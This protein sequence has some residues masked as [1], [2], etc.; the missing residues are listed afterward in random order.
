MTDVSVLAR[1]ARDTWGFL[2]V[3]VALVTVVFALVSSLL[4]IGAAKF[5]TIGSILDTALKLYVFVI[6]IIAVGHLV[7]LV[8]GVGAWFR[9]NDRRI[10]GTFGIFLNIGFVMGSIVAVIGTLRY[11]L[12]PYTGFSV[13]SFPWS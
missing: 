9:R 8:L 12:T 5:T 3:L 11:V 10:L 2:S 13:P 6:L 4:L 7:S 1:R